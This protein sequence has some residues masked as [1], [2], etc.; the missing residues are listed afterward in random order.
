MGW[1]KSCFWD[2]CEVSTFIIPIILS[3][4]NDFQR[5]MCHTVGVLFYVLRDILI[6]YKCFS[7]RGRSGTGGRRGNSIFKAFIGDEYLRFDWIVGMVTL[8][9]S[10]HLHFLFRNSSNV[11]LFSLLAS[12]LSSRNR[13]PEEL[14]KEYKNIPI[15]TDQCLYLAKW[16]TQRFN[17]IFFKTWAQTVFVKFFMY[18]QT[19]PMHFKCVL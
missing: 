10:L 14:G 4:K 8:K 16:S 7:I 19:V 17:L 12:F 15:N 3:N 1:L 6:L 11:C 5:L 13:W 9:T 18:T 2:S